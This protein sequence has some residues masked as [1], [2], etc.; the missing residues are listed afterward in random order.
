[1]S[2]NA[3]M[4][5]TIIPYAPEYRQD[6]TDI[7]L[8]WLRTYFTVEPVDEQVLN[9][10]ETHILDQGGEIYFA[11]NE[12]EEIIGAVAFKNH[13]DGVYELS[14]MGVRPAAQGRGAGEA[15]VKKVI[16]RFR[17]VNGKKLYIESNNKLRGAI[18]LYE[19]N[20]FHHC[21]FPF[22]SGFKRANVYL[23]WF[24]SPAKV[25]IHPAETAA[26][27]LQV[28]K[29]FT[30]YA[31][32]LEHETG[33]SLAFQGFEAE[34]RDFPAKYKGLLLAVKKQ[35]PIGAVALLHHDDDTCEMKRL[36]VDPNHQRSGAGRNLSI[37][38]MNVA[39]HFG[40]KTMVLDSLRRLKP[41]VEL[42]IRLGFNER[43]AY[44]ENPEDDVIY[45]SKNL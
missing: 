18:Y 10:P 37:A 39:C 16:D 3:D 26:E 2:D 28:K 17:A 25:H 45:M 6:F 31:T 22:K 8:E 36:W 19:K 14:K 24:E 15:L 30:D 43:S 9:S 20:G 21:P 34:M 7:N 38:L 11:K 32:W 29:F 40:Y 33:L 44:N 13:G 23:E 4:S 12:A 42:Y 35:Q 5:V 41:A 1:M 27:I